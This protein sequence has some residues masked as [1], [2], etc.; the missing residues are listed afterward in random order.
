MKENVFILKNENSSTKK[1]SLLWFLLGRHFES[2]QVHAGS[3][4][5]REITEF[6]ISCHT[7]VIANPSR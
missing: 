6:V 7:I 2:A 1:F 3:S 5:P 4:T